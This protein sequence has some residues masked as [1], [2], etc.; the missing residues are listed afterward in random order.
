MIYH[1]SNQPINAKDKSKEELIQEIEQL[2]KTNMQ[3]MQAQAEVYEK[4]EKDK[5]E[6][7]KAIAEC[8]ELNNPKG[9]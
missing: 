5:L 3:L 1:I 9:V 6:I 2:K 8:Y 4:E 7:M